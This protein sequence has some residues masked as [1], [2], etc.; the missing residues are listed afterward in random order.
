MSGGDG[1][2]IETGMLPRCRLLIEPVAQSGAWNMAVDEALLESVLQGELPIV[3][4]YRWSEPTLSLG[5]FQ[6]LADVEQQSHWRDTPKV[7]RLTGGGAILHDDE[8]TYSCIVPATGDQWLR[9]PYDLYDLV[10][11]AIALW[12]RQR[13]QLPVAQ[14]GHGSRTAEEPT[15]CFLRQDSH[16]LVLFNHKV[17]GSAQRRRKGVL[18][19]HGSLVVRRSA[20]TPELPGLCD[21]AAAASLAIPPLGET[22]RAELA[23]FVAQSLARAVIPGDL[24]AAETVLAHQLM[25]CKTAT[26]AAAS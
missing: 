10:H 2:R 7:R 1:F 11:D 17:L 3:R 16:D 21:L 12:F 9:H 13:W 25:T 20:V 5:Y 22:H 24:T 15:L 14:R 4:W 19:Q 8:W 6:S 18:L 23:S 26:S